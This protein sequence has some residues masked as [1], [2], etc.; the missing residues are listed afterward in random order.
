MACGHEI[1]RAWHTRLCVGGVVVAMISSLSAVVHGVSV[2]AAMPTQLQDR[3]SD[4]QDESDGVGSRKPPSAS[5]CVT[6]NDCSL[7]GQC[8][9]QGRN[10]QRECACDVGWKGPT[11]GLLDLEPAYSVA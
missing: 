8:A 4:H 9:P 5:A 7:N 3:G 6:D 10:L 11:C 2:G 1:M